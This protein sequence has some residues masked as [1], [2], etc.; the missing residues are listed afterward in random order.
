[1]KSFASSFSREKCCFL[2]EPLD[3]SISFLSFCFASS[4]LGGSFS[5]SAE[6]HPAQQMTS[7][8]EPGSRQTLC[9]LLWLR[10]FPSSQTLP[11][12]TSCSSCKSQLKIQIIFYLQ[13]GGWCF[14]PVR[15]VVLIC[16]VLWL[17]SVR[18]KQLVK[19]FWS[20]RGNYGMWK[21]Q[22]QV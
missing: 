7:S 6:A 18:Q 2:A 21:V 5:P 10:I 8:T 20:E 17:K 11:L 14:H 9:R 3:G 13:T 16:L 22:R 19:S 1:M 15:F 4:P 12:F